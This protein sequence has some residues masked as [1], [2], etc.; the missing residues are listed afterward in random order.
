MSWARR[1]CVWLGWRGGVVL[2][3]C[4]CGVGGVDELKQPEHDQHTPRG[5]IT[6]NSNLHKSKPCLS[7]PKFIIPTQIISS[8]SHIPYEI[9]PPPH[10]RVIATFITYLLLTHAFTPPHPRSPLPQS[11]QPH[12][13]PP[14]TDFDTPSQPSDPPSPS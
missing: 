7:I 11:P 2:L 13:P 9:P 5:L 4:C 6:E 8:P 3:R 12:P 1:R 14:H 10:N